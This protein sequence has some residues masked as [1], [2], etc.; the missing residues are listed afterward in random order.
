MAGA[1]VA[2]L[3]DAPHVVI[4]GAGFGGLK[5]A[6]G[7]RRAACQITVIDKRNYHLFQSLLYQVATASLSPADIATPIRTMFR[8]QHNVRVV[9]GEVMD[10]NTA[11]LNDGSRMGYDY[12]VLATGARHSYFGRDDWE[13]YAPG[14]KQIE[15]AT[16][17]RWRLLLAF[18]QAENCA[19]PA[20]RQK[21]LT[22][23]IVGGGPTGVELAGAMARWLWGAARA[24]ERRVGEECGSR[25]PPYH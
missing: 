12:L 11:M 21:L 10:V 1:T 7:L 14:L 9:L 25:W 18:E 2:A 22:F 20:E 6:H 13:P 24:E 17:I 23:V 3:A 19:D 5:A 16:A 15:D 8:D 4:V